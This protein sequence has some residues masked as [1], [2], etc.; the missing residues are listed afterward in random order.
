[1]KRAERKIKPTSKRLEKGRIEN[2]LC[3]M[4][5]GER[6]DKIGRCYRCVLKAISYVC[7]ETR[8]RWK[9]IGLILFEKQNQTCV[10]S[11]QPIKLGVDTSIDHRVPLSRGGTHAADNLQWVRI[12]INTAKSGLLEEEFLSMISQIHSHR[13]AS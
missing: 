4:C 6:Q 11:G 9:E 3:H 12:D 2:G 8:Y 7:L 10:Y 5:S 13:L 1:M